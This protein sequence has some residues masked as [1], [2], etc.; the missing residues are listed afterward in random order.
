MPFCDNPCRCFREHPCLYFR[1]S[2]C[3]FMC[4]RYRARTPTSICDCCDFFVYMS[5][6]LS[7][8]Q[9]SFYIPPL[10]GKSIILSPLSRLISDFL[11]S[12]LLSSWSI[13][14]LVSAYCSLVSSHLSRR[15]LSSPFLIYLYHASLL[16]S[17]LVTFF[18]YCWYLQS[19]L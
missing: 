6:V 5:V 18:L 15:S 10:A 2:V 19:S 11:G 16:S 14:S 13:G 12:L 9:R 7:N 17:C 1:V 4:F 3:L 8:R